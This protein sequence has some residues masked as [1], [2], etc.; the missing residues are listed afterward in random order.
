MALDDDIGYIPLSEKLCENG[1]GNSGLLGFLSINSHK[2]SRSK[3]LK[4]IYLSE[5]VEIIGKMLGVFH[6][7]I[8]RSK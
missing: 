1:I 2:Y 5:I 8:M 7:G 3:F 6:D 4:I